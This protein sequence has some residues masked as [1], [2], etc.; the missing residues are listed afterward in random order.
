[1]NESYLTANI[2]AGTG[3]HIHAVW[4]NF[5]VPSAWCSH[6]AERRAFFRQRGC[7]DWS[8]VYSRVEEHENSLSHRSSVDAYVTAN[9]NLDVASM[10]NVA[11]M[12]ERR[13]Q[14]AQNRFVVGRL[15]D[16]IFFVGKMG[17]AYQGKHE[18]CY[19]MNEES[20]SR[21]IFLDLV[22]LVSKYDVSLKR[23]LDKVISES[24][25]RKDNTAG[26]GRGDLV[27]FLSKTTINKLIVIIG[28]LF[29]EH[30]S[31]KV[32]RGDKFSV[33]L[34][35]TQDIAVVE[36]CSIV[37]RFVDG[38]SVRERLLS[39]VDVKQST[40]QSY[41]DYLQEE[42]VKNGLEVKNIIGCSFDGAANVWSV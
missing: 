17:L 7:Q 36:Q 26:K 10:I 38:L 18:A 37:V 16:I 34:D 27:T 28:Q 15:I 23:H 1:M 31:N 35:S 42:L 13:R 6:N 20:A 11:L 41:F 3:C 22:M 30:I 4:K 25:K 5:S 14:V 29:K 24:K 33:Q 40:G 19:F 8:H 39:F 2:L 12:D 32:K 9:S 21:G